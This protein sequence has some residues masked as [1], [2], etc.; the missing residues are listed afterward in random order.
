MSP[1]ALASLLIAAAEERPGTSDC[2]AI[3]AGFFGQPINSLS[4]LGLVVAG[5]WLAQT[6]RPGRDQPLAWA[7]IGLLVANGLGSMLYHGPGWPWTRFVHDL[8]IASTALLVALLLAVGSRRAFLPW[9]VGTGILA[10]AVA[11]NPDVAIPAT[12][13]FAVAVGVM[14]V[15]RLVKYRKISGQWKLE[16]AALGAL[17][18]GAAFTVLGRTGQPLCEPDSFFQPHGLWHLLMAVSLTLLGLAMFRDPR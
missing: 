4:S 11:I 7:Y 12:V 8:P 13:V 3:T 16:T 5:V 2:E 10:V 9:A 17:A 15:V 14:A 18:V 1:A 6:L